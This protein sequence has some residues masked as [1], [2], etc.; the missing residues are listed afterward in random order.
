[1]C[2]QGL[3]KIVP[4]AGA[5]VL[6]GACNQQINNVLPSTGTYQVD[7]LAGQV[8]LEE[9]SV[10]AQGETLLPYFV[11]SVADDPDLRR[12][13]LY[14]ESPEGNTLGQ[15]VSYDTA[16]DF[17]QGPAEGG[18]AEGRTVEDGRS[19]GETSGNLPG[20]LLPGNLPLE[21]GKEQVIPVKSFTGKLPPFPLPA[22]LA[23]GAY[24]L[25]FEIRG[26]RD[27]LS[28]VRR[29]FYY[30]GDREFT[31][32]DI[33]CYLPE[34]YENSHVVPQGLTVMLETPV[35]FGEGL[36]PYVVWYNGKSRIGEGPVSAGAGR[37]LWTTPPRSGFQSIRAE[38]FP[39]KPVS[40]Q[41]GRA[42][43]FSLP[44]SQKIEKASSN[45]VEKYLYWYQFAGDLL[46]ARTGTELERVHSEI[47]PLSWY[48]GERVYGLAL[49]NGEV[50]EA[51]RLPLSLFK[52]DEGDLC[53]F[54]RFLPLE[55]GRIFSARLGSSLDIGLFLEEG[56]LILDLKEEGK[57]FRISRA[58]PEP[59]RVPD[60]IGILV[61]LRFERGGT[62]ASL[63]LADPPVAAGAAGEEILSPEEAGHSENPRLGLTLPLPG[64]L[65][66]WIG[67]ALQPEDEGNRRESPAAASP[68]ESS[69]PAAVSPR[70]VLVLD[71]F[72]L[73]F[74]PLPGVEAEPPDSEVDS[75]DKPAAPL[76]GIFT[77]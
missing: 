71:D 67:A 69:G 47:S 56:V 68:V 54:I 33:R 3:K 76:F 41:K 49:G 35:S 38:F 72:A 34:F 62:S 75:D 25:V 23:I 45:P 1:M 40:G 30:I 6:M 21:P 50:Y 77:F 51:S 14:V 53:F 15:R 7:V 59:G 74:R 20:G 4:L 16:A 32:G 43:E 58:L 17:P 70:P 8:S 13:V 64:E 52:Q 65:R 26:E 37:L 22:D 55:N 36:E 73:L 39:F 2:V 63:L 60:F 66:S 28:R 18:A 48:P 11:N 44:I 19:A 5:L 27:V 12:L 61:L 31:A 24:S 46:D 29:P 42:R 57:E 9:C 10:I